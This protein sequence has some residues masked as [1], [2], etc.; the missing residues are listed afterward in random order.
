[1]FEAFP[2]LLPILIVSA[3]LDSINPCAISVLLITLGFFIEL[4]SESKKVKIIGFFYIL[5][6]YLT[7][8]LIGL[9]ILR[10]LTFF[11]IP[12]FF[13]LLAGG[14][15]I[16]WGGIELSQN[17]FPRVKQL[18]KIPDF[19]HSQIAI[20]IQRGTLPAVFALG[21]LVAMFEFPCTGG[22]YLSILALLRGQETYLAG[23]GYLLIYNLIF[24]SPLIAINLIA[25]NPLLLERVQKFRKKHSRTF[26]L[27]SGVIFLI[28]G[29]IIFLLN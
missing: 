1:M 19:S 14:L 13:S 11:G 2:A 24:V 5:G 23:L 18:F 20:L 25:G 8:F 28:L 12:N 26:S 16:V 7:Y 17:F 6:A 9:G 15:M 22:P 10:V 27:I 29:I 3:L 4:G 21:S